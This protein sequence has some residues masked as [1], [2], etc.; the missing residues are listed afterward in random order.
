MTK[1]ELISF[2]ESQYRFE[3]ERR[4]KIDSRLQTPFAVIIGLI[5]AISYVSVHP[6]PAFCWE[7]GHLGRHFSGR[8]ARA[9]R[10][11]ERLLRNI[12]N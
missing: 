11:S 4:D 7:R 8:V 9:P 12:R 5:G 3:I 1:K 6:P 2:Y 10:G